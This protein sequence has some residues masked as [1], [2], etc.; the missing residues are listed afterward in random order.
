M[1]RPNQA[2]WSCICQQ[3]LLLQM[4]AVSAI[5]TA[6]CR[7]PRHPTTVPC[8]PPAGPAQSVWRAVAVQHR[9][10]LCHAGPRSAAPL[11]GRAGQRRQGWVARRVAGNALHKQHTRF[12]RH[13]T[14]LFTRHFTSLGLWTAGL[15]LTC[16][17][18]AHST[19]PSRGAPMPCH[20][21]LQASCLP[22]SLRGCLCWCGR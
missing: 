13:F 9:L 14:R 21:P 8:V 16:Y 2:R 15:R 20:H 6:A 22:L 4:H 3:L 17:H 19:A 18:V 11:L 7:A 5:A 10:G 1:R 12:T